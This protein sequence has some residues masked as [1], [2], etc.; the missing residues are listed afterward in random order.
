M[1]AAIVISPFLNIIRHFC[2]IA[3][4]NFGKCIS[5]KPHAL[6]RSRIQIYKRS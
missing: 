1:I 6:Q 5:R 3:S 2:R 4:E